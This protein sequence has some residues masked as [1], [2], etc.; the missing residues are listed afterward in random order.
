MFISLNGINETVLIEKDFNLLLA[1]V[2]LDVTRSKKEIILNPQPSE[3]NKENKVS[4]WFK[5]TISH[6]KEQILGKDIKLYN[7]PAEI[8]ALQDVTLLFAYIS[9]NHKEILSKSEIPLTQ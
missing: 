1:K 2:A 6:L 9:N 8:L 7:T 5:D 4:A 3:K